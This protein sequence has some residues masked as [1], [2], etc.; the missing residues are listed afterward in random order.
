VAVVIAD[1]P[2][3]AQTAAGILEINYAAEARAWPFDV[4]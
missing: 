2:T 4:Q 1:D 3:T